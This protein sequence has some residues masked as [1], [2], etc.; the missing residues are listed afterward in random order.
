MWQ[1]PVAWGCQLIPQDPSQ[2]AMKCLWRGRPAGG[3][4]CEHVAREVSSIG[5]QLRALSP[6]HCCAHHRVASGRCWRWTPTLASWCSAQRAPGRRRRASHGTRARLLRSCLS[7]PGRKS[8]SC[9]SP[10]E[11]AACLLTSSCMLKR[12]LCSSLGAMVLC[13]GAASCPL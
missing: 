4:Y 10:S 6:M 12:W 2:V 13:R 7:A 8:G 11:R 3:L 9:P 5:R 1:V